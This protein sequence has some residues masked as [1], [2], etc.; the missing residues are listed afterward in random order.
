MVKDITGIKPILGK[1]SLAYPEPPHRSRYDEFCRCPVEFDA[2][3]TIFRVLHPDLDASVQ[4]RNQEMFSICAEHCREVMRSAPNSNRLREQ[5]RE[6]FL[7]SPGTLPNIKE[8]SVSLGISPITMHRQLAASGKSYQ[9]IKDQFR[10]DLSRE[11]LLSGHMSS[12]Q[13]AYFLGFASPSAFARAFKTWSGK[14]VGQFIAE[15]SE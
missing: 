4:T 5:L 6:I 13:V 14:T 12:K 10:F 8:A 15:V 7:A 1:V 3:K 11:Y 9:A 2:P